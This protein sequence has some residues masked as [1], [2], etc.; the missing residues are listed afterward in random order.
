LLIFFSIPDK[1][2]VEYYREMGVTRTVFGLPSAPADV[3]LPL[4]DKYAELLP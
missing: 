2:K 3:V 1:G 4:L